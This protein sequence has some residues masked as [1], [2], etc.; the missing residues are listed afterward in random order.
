M[1]GS[2]PPST[3][4]LGLER[5]TYPS[6]SFIL[7]S[8]TSRTMQPLPIGQQARIYV[9]HMRS[10]RLDSGLC[11]PLPWHNLSTDLIMIQAT[12]PTSIYRD[13]FFVPKVL[14]PFISV[15]AKI[16]SQ[17]IKLIYL[18]SYSTTTSNN[19][20][21]DCGSGNT[22]G[23]S[24]PSSCTCGSSCSCKQCGVRW[25]PLPMNFT[26]HLQTSIEV[27]SC[28]PIESSPNWSPEWWIMTMINGKGCD[29]P[30]RGNVPLDYHGL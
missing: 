14:K 1:W 30:R 6:A 3:P 21:C 17:T 13:N 5:T 10:V 26:S 18:S 24:G 4:G 8:G 25:D 19:M 27:K 20:G 9:R 22:C 12:A 29:S 16:I 23:C 15:E 7:K 11:L 28:T 2:K